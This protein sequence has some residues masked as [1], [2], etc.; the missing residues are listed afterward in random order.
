MKGN[1]PFIFSFRY[2]G[3]TMKFIWKGGMYKSE[4][5]LRAKLDSPRSSLFAI[6]C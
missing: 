1:N 4:T 6:L 3:W 2:I 5:K